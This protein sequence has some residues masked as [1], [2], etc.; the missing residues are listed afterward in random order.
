MLE[1]IQ[2]L[3][4]WVSGL[5]TVPKLAITAVVLLL[6]FVFLY[7]VW[8]PPRVVTPGEMPAVREAYER[9]RR[10]LSRLGTSET[11][12]ITVDGSPIEEGLE[13]YYSPFVAISEYVSGHPQDIR[14]AYEKIWE[15]GG[16]GRVMINDTEA[17]ETVVSAFFAEYDRV[18]KAR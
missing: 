6:T 17:F 10:V 13:K 5:P 18:T 7:L 8:A 3:V 14:G 11:G 1:S 16:A 12:R 9:M 2:K 15:H 4:P